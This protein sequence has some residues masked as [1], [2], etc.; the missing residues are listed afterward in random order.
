M[1]RSNPLTA[2][3]TDER[4]GRASLLAALLGVVVPVVLALVARL[5][6]PEAQTRSVSV[7]CLLWFAACQLSAAVLGVRAAGTAS[8]RAGLAVAVAGLALLALSWS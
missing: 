7:L 3:P 4:L 2:L 6:L 5:T 1:S 8:G